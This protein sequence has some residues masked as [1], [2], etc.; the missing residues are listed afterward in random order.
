MHASC[1][2][3]RSVENEAASAARCTVHSLILSLVLLGIYNSLPISLSLSRTRTAIISFALFLYM[4]KAVMK[5]YPGQYLVH[6]LSC[7]RLIASLLPC[8]RNT[9]T[10][11]ILVHFWCILSAYAIYNYHEITENFHF[12][13]KSSTQTRICKKK[14]LCR[15]QLASLLWKGNRSKLK[16][17][18]PLA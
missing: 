6:A 18:V 11:Y 17:G 15:P 1:S 9:R 13:V 10:V 5:K 12:W 2:C 16:P 14:L 7:Y 8:M 4:P 3:K